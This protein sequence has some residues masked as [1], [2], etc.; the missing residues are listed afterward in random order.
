ML[1]SLDTKSFFPVVDAELGH[2]PART[3]MSEAAHDLDRSKNAG[4]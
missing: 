2:T 1:N 4:N 3:S